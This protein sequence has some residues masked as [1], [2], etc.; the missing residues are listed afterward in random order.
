V[1][2]ERGVVA[3]QGTAFA[4][5]GTTGSGKKL[6]GRLPPE[7]WWK[8]TDA[9]R[10]K[11]SAKRKTEKEANEAAEKKSK[12]KSKDVDDDDDD[13]SI[14]SLKKK[15]SLANTQLKAVTNSLFTI[16]EKDDEHSDLS[17]EG[18]NHLAMLELSPMLGI[19]YT[20][21]II[22]DGG[23][24]KLNLFDKVL[25]DSC[26]THN[27]M[28]N[29]KFLGDIKTTK[30]GLNMNGN[31]GQLK[32]NKKGIIP[33]LYPDGHKP[34]TSWYTQEGIANLLSFKELTKVYRITYDS[35]KC[36]SFT[37]HRSEYG[38][39]DLHFKMHESGLHILVKPDGCRE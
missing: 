5:A 7:E 17:E 28:C 37:V 33:W 31:G 39:V 18:S 32:I 34:A 30:K 29:K 8:L 24:E 6:K 35:D 12:P 13:E 9:E 14:K 21:Q 27:I 3:A 11:I 15:L 26:T 20:Q 36:T 4:G 16:V 22:K 25:L 38:L 23:Q 10:L 19:W 2:P 1:Q